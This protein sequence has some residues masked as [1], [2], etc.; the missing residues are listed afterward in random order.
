MIYN[1]FVWM[2]EHPLMSGLCLIALVLLA[3][4][5]IRA[6]IINVIS[7]IW[8]FIVRIFD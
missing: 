1:W 2:V 5:E 3:I 7:V 4:R 6:S 8:Y